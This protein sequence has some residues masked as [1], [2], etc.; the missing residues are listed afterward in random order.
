MAV[1]FPP[2][3]WLF[4]VA[5]TFIF[6]A[7][8][9]TNLIGVRLTLLIA[10]TFF[11]IWAIIILNI[12]GDTV[13]WNIGHIVLNIA[14]VIPLIIKEWPIIFKG[15]TRE[16]YEKYF[17]SR[18]SKKQF[19][20]LISKARR[21]EIDITDT[22]LIQQG[23]TFDELFFVFR[24]PKSKSV[25]ITFNQQTVHTSEE[26]DFIGMLE[27]TLFLRKERLKKIHIEQKANQKDEEQLH[28]MKSNLD[29]K[30]R[31]DISA[32]IE[33]GAGN[34]DK[35]PLIYYKWERE[36]LINILYDKEHGRA[37]LNALYSIWLEKTI[38]IIQVSQDQM[39]LEYAHRLTG[40]SF[41]FKKKATKYLPRTLSMLY[42][43]EDSNEQAN[44]PLVPEQVIHK[45][46]F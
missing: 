27:A 9:Q 31:W 39:K 46:K 37:I 17:K 21:K 13:L 15:E 26:G 12:S 24:I 43:V 16:V 14:L 7:Y 20:L 23:N 29:E 10:S 25:S 34:N 28:Y 44:I 41:D 36:D 1:I 3:H 32:R 8:I 4:Q 18:L 35:E 5:E 33:Q 19:R 38:K 6:L 45:K 11:L 2:S 22:Q 40:G 42:Q 30:L